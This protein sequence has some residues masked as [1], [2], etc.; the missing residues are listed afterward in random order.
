MG[1]PSFLMACRELFDGPAELFDGL[2]ISI[3]YFLSHMGGIMAA[4]AGRPA[5]SLAR[6]GRPANQSPVGYPINPATQLIN[7]VGRPVRPSSL[8]G[9]PIKLFIF[10][11]GPL[12]NIIYISGPFIIRNYPRSFRFIIYIPP[13]AIFQ[14]V[15]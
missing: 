5:P 4:P 12:S 14:I 8:I 10:L 11:P 7:S 15:I 1:L 13:L 9:H 3:P 2:P 6:Y